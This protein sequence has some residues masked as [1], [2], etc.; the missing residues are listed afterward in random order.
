KVA[1]DWNNAFPKL[2]RYKN[3]M[4]LLKRNGPVLYGVE[5]EKFLSTTYRPRIVLYSL[6]D[7]NSSKLVTSIN[8]TARDKKKLEVSIE[9]KLHEQKYEE[10]IH[11]L[12]EQSVLDFSN[13]MNIEGFIR[14]IFQF[15]EEKISGNPFWSC[16]T[17]MFL[18][19]FVDDTS[20]QNKF[21]ESAILTIRQKVLAPHL[22]LQ[23]G[24]FDKWIENKKKISRTELEL[25]MTNNIIKHKLQDF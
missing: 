6:L 19:K 14:A 8:Y 17:I 11:Y 5:L 24:D 3:G 15:I 13:E 18:S 23:I 22:K 21:F 1:I 20:L 10:A 16:E 4:R 2:K 7:E 9:Y 12:K 25:T